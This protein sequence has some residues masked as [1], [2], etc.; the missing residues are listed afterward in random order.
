M[1]ILVVGAGVVGTVYGTHL[2]AAGNDVSVLSHNARTNEIAR[3][4]LSAHDVGSG[5]RFTG[6]ATIVPDAGRTTYDLVVVAIQRDQ[7]ESAIPGLHSLVGAPAVVFFGNNV[8]SGSSS[9]RG[10]PGAHFLGFPG[11]GGVMNGATADYVLIHPQPTTLQ[12][13][14]DPRLHDLERALIGR[15]F[16]V[17][18]EDDMGGWL[19]YHSAFIACIS[20]A[21]YRCGTDPVRLAGDRATLTLMCRAIT[22]AFV[23]LHASGARGLPRNLAVLHSSWLRPVAIR[24][25]ARTMR[26]PQ[27]ELWFAT[28]IRHAEPEMKALE[29]DLALR[30]PDSCSIRELLRHGGSDTGPLSNLPTGAAG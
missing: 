1:K 9:A 24:Y 18:R 10:I 23:G 17:E 13:S 8:A 19:T 5:G 25:W 15:G 28:H 22:E 11:V 16:P 2:A 6:T 12:T 29:N 21:L 4:G 14:P 20:A 30:L 27:G 3:G 26:S 7:L